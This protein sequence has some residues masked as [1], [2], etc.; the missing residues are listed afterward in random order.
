MRR[1]RPQP[2]SSSYFLNGFP[3]PTSRAVGDGGAVAPL[4][5]IPYNLRAGHDV[6]DHLTR[7]NV[8]SQSAYPYVDGNNHLTPETPRLRRRRAQRGQVFPLKK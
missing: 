1:C 5:A 7:P 4:S 3:Q 6:H 8:P 2:A